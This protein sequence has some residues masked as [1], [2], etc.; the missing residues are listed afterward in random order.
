MPEV[1]KK[2]IRVP[3][4]II[5]NGFE[6]L[7]RYYEFNPGLFQ[8]HPSLLDAKQS[9][10]PRKT[11]LHNCALVCMYACMFVYV[12]CVCVCMFEYIN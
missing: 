2:I 11:F 6:P 9:S 8:Q 3:G 10:H 4:N 1:R 12:C 7:Y 5:K